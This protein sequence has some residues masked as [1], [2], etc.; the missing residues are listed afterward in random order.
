MSSAIIAD[1]EVS[2]LA[3][4][5]GNDQEELPAEMARYLLN[6]GFNARD[7][8]RMHELSIRNQDGDLSD[9]EKEELFAYAKTGS[10]LSI[11]KS[12]ARRVLQ[13]KPKKRI[14]P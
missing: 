6:R 8:E 13:I 2:I 11:L 12:K 3:R 10:V 14:A 5:L 4:V 9:E 1:H 7:K